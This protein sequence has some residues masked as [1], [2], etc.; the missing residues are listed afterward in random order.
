MLRSSPHVRY[1]RYLLLL[2]D[3]DGGGDDETI[4]RRL[5]REGFYWPEPYLV[6]CI[7]EQLPLTPEGFDIHNKYCQATRRYLC[8]VEVD[9]FAWPDEITRHAQDIRRSKPE[10]QAYIE[11]AALVAPPLR[12]IVAGLAAKL[13][14]HTTE[15]ILRRYL[16]LYWD[17]HQVDRNEMVMILKSRYHLWP[18]HESPLRKAL[19]QLAKQEC[20]RDM[21]V[22]VAHVPPGIESAMAWMA[23]MG[24]SQS[25]YDDSK[26]LRL[27]KSETAGRLRESLY[28]GGRED[29]K[30]ANEFMSVW[31]MANELLADIADPNAAVAERLNALRM[32]TDPQPLPLLSEVSHGQHTTELH[33][34]TDYAN[35]NPDTEVEEDAH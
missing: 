12:G 32:N 26:M 15:T 11:A 23:N 1:I 20:Y 5:D 27:I 8:E 9:Q 25:N 13:R 6:G 10:V 4:A 35:H 3:V 19:A 24:V 21:R 14:F 30:K 28:E 18:M 34:T 22:R 33:K 7:R 2:P 29:S 31:K 16:S 17:T